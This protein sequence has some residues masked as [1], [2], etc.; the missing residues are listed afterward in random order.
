M[1]GEQKWDYQRAGENSTLVTADIDYSLQASAIGDLLTKVAERF[2]LEKMEERAIH[3]TLE[4]L[5]FMVEQ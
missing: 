4:N 2:L 1:Q 3:Q 5:K